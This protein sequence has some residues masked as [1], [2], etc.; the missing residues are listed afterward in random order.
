M[1]AGSSRGALGQTY[2]EGVRD[3]G[4]EH[5]GRETITPEHEHPLFVRFARVPA[6][7][8]IDAVRQMLNEPWY[9]GPEEALE[10]TV[11]GIMTESI[12]LAGLHDLEVLRARDFT[13]DGSGERR[14]EI[15]NRVTPVITA[16]EEAAAAEWGRPTVLGRAEDPDE[17]TLLQVMLYSFGMPDVL[18]WQVGDRYVVFHAG[19]KHSD[20]TELTVGFWVSSRSCVENAVYAISVEPDD[21][22]PDDADGTDTGAAVARARVEGIDI[23]VDLSP[24][25]DAGAEPSG[26]ERRF[27]RRL[28]D[29]VALPEELRRAWAFMESQGWGGEGADGTPF[30]TPFATERQLGAVFSAD[31]SIEGWLN[32]RAPGAERIVPLA[33]TD[34]SGGMAA[35]WIDDEGAQRYIWLSSESGEAMRLADSA[36][37]FLRLIAIGYDELTEWGFGAPPDSFADTVEHEDLEEADL[38]SR[39]PVVAHAKFRSWVEAAFGVTVPDLWEAEGDE[40]FNAWIGPLVERHGVA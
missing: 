35:L 15:M 9:T 29:G 37:D 28:P 13:D 16:L 3:D 33:E 11:N 4:Q 27:A 40:A 26:L 25:G 34:G 5:E 39:D 18:S 23:E 19:Q 32:P 7:Q 10:H 2:P 12:S 24:A 20:T 30:L 22:N 6:D 31:L 21:N 8:A 14:T 36:V 17:A 1:E 38:E